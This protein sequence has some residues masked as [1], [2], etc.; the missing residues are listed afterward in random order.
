M[1]NRKTLQNQARNQKTQ[2]FEIRYFFPIA[3]IIH[4]KQTTKKINYNENQY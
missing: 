1:R 3:K 2:N 4:K